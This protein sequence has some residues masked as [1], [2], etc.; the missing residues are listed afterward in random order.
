MRCFFVGILA[1]VSCHNLS[2]Q[3]NKK[4]DDIDK[5]FTKIEIDAT[6]DKK[7][8]AAYIKKAAVLPDS[9]AATIPAGTYKITIQFIVDKYGNLG[10][11]KAKDNPGYGLAKRAESI[12]SHYEGV[13][14]P[15][16]QCGREVKSY[17]QQVV[18]F[19]VRKSVDTVL[20]DN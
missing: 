20:N 19:I 9:I 12:I 14:S 17:K 6:T 5:V 11:V 15:A 8:W 1:V 4:E 3:Q 2:A 18:E 13:W 16:S 7:A 10:E